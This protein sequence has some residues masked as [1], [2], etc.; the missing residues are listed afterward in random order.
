MTDIRCTTCHR[1]LGSFDEPEITITLKCPNCKSLTRYHSVDLS[2]YV[3]KSAMMGGST[4]AQ[5][6]GRATHPSQP[7][8]TKAI[9]K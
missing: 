6:K 9:E 5:I 1:Y 8:Y 4:E 7:I 3:P 2:R